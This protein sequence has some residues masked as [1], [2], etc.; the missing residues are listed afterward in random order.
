ME[1]VSPEVGVV[2]EA[3]LAGLLDDDL[4]EGASLLVDLSRA[5]DPAVREAARRL[6]VR[7]VVPAARVPGP[8]VRAGSARLG[9]VREPGLD[10]D[11]D[12]TF[13]RFGETAQ[14][15]AG[16]LRWR[17][18]CRPG[19]AVVLVVDASGSMTGPALTTAV[20]TAAA[21]AARC[22]P[23][24]EVAVVAFSSRVLVLRHMED[25]APPDTVLLRLLALRGGDTTD[26]AAGLRVA[27]GQ[28]A[29][30][31]SGRRDVIVLSD[32]NAN[33][34]SDPVGVA[35]SAPGVGARIHV[36]ATSEEEGSLEACRALAEAGGGAMLPLRRPGDAP[37][38]VAEL[39]RA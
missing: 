22:G 5:T 29:R 18:W 21:V 20:V 16:D 27:L 31:R 23:A 3:A 6:A 7:L 2:D 13:D 35:A 26:L 8:A 14:L 28:A 30:S 37:A 1:E 38:A 32:G 39:L 24:D 9:P 15:R 17:G 19:R 10:L 34:G 4:E 33:E 25:P 12:A 11:L 36:L